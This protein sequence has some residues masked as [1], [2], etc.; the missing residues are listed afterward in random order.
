[1][2][3]REG[4]RSV[5][6]IHMPTNYATTTAIQHRASAIS[7]S[8]TC[9]AP[10]RRSVRSHTHAHAHARDTAT[11]VVI[12]IRVPT[13]TH[14]FIYRVWVCACMRLGLSFFFYVSS[15]FPPPPPLLQRARISI[16][17]TKSVAR[18]IHRRHRTQH[19]RPSDRPTVASSS[20]RCCWLA[21]VVYDTIS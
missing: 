15:R 10:S 17:P 13:N 18:P 11:R 9:T 1:M 12:I 21:S 14:L 3:R 5:A 20:A 8:G 16:I 6:C 19:V 4:R 7:L 2:R